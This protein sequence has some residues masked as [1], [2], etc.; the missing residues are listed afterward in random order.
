M[1]DDDA[2]PF[3]D[4]EIRE[5]RANL[6]ATRRWI[7]LREMTFTFVTRLTAVIGLMFLI[8]QFGW[9]IMSGRGK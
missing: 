4:A 8:R 5:I 2:T 1:A 7:W 6:I 3:T 9:E